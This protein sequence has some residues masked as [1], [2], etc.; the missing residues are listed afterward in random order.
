MNWS[1]ILSI[2]AAV[3]G[4]IPAIVKAWD[5]APSNS[6]A[7]VGAVIVNTPVVSQL[8]D[9]GSQLFPK[10]SPELHAAA[11]A[12]VIAHPNNTSWVQSALNVLASTGYIT[13]SPPLVV[14]GLYG[15]K[16][17]AAVE[18]VQT[19][20]HLPV[21]G[22]AADAEFAAIQSLLTKA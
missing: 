21:T 1:A 14:D 17:K 6:L 12:L 18:A 20:L 4:E 8:T 16:T 19:K 7:K 15:P 13:L 5:T 2:V 9:I 22:F 10:L 11:A 3:V